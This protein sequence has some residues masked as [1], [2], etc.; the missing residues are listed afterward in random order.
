MC[1]IAKNQCKRKC[2]V[3]GLQ[4]VVGNPDR[5]RDG[6]HVTDNPTLLPPFPNRLRV[7]NA[8]TVPYPERL[9]RS[10]EL[11]QSPAWPLQYPVLKMAANLLLPFIIY[12]QCTGHCLY[13]MHLSQCQS[14]SCDSKAH[15]LPSLP[16]VEDSIEKTGPHQQRPL[17]GS[18]CGLYQPTSIQAQV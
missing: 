1:C 3:Q 16:T 12:T 4:E 9:Q 17:P 15:I 11:S 6:N 7:I 5:A 18:S 14:R 10:P 2:V 13:P 8:W